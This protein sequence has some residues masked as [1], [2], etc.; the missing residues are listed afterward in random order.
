MRPIICDC[1]GV[2]LDWETGFRRWL[3]AEC[4]A[5]PSPDGPVSWDMDSWVGQPAAPLVERFNA[6]EKFGQLLPMRFAIESVIALHKRG[7]PLFVLTS[8]SSEATIANRRRANL[9]RFFG[10]RFES[11][12]CLD[13]GQ[14]KA[15]H[16]EALRDELGPCFWV[17][18]HPGHG[19][20]GYAAGHSVYMKRHNHNRSAETS[21][22]PLTW[23]DDWREIKSHIMGE[24]HEAVSGIRRRNGTESQHRG[25]DR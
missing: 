25:P 20:A 14:K 7:H 11:I 10:N 6:S 4:I 19:R 21:D 15:S 8:C 2:L 17:E 23:V 12:T 22:C 18:D 5:N 1:D 24:T 3:V 16:L 13:L 9:E